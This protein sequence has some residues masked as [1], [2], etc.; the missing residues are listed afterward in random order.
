[1]WARNL[2]PSQNIFSYTWKQ[3]MI[4]K[5]EVSWQ[6]KIHT[7][8]T[9]FSLQETTLFLSSPTIFGDGPWESFIIHLWVFNTARIL[10]PQEASIGPLR[11]LGG[12]IGL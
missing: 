3:I 12:V 1:M 9:I 10:I 7:K 4:T 6:K 11:L 5:L 8:S 2:R